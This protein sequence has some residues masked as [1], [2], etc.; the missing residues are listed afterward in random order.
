MVIGAGAAGAAA[1]FHLSHLGHRVTLL[2]RDVDAQA[3][4]QDPACGRIKPCGGGMAA[5]VQQWFPFTLSPAVD[6]V[7]KRV[8]FSWCLTDPVVAE[9]P[10]S[11]PFWI[12]R[13]ERLDALL[14]SQAIDNGAELC[15]GFEV[16][17]LRREPQG[18]WQVSSADGRSREAHAVVIADEVEQ[19]V[20][21]DPVGPAGSVGPGALAGGGM[22]VD[23]AAAQR[24]TQRLAVRRAQRLEAGADPHLQ[25]TPKAGKGSGK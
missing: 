17:E 4:A 24:L 9:L 16:T 21:M 2:E 7:I 6:E 12:V 11:A 5:S 8:E 14:I 20:G 13:R 23:P 1:A 25:Y 19:D 22:P 18:L 10:G 15:S 3:G